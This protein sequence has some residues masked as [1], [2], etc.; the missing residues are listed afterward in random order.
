MVEGM[1]RV[2]GSRGVHRAAAGAA[3]GVG[4]IRGDDTLLVT[5][6]SC[7]SCAISLFSCKLHKQNLDQLYI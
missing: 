6:F 4:G 7:S 5:V 2:L 1:P 3:M